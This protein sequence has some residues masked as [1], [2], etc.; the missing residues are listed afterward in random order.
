[1]EAQQCRK[2]ARPPSHRTQ[3]W[4][5]PF[6]GT[7]HSDQI[8]EGWTQILCWALWNMCF[9]GNICFRYIFY[10]ICICV[11]MSSLSCV[12]WRNNL[13]G[14][15][16]LTTFMTSKCTC[17]NLVRPHASTG[18]RP[19][20]PKIV[21]MRV[22]QFCKFSIQFAT[23]LLTFRDKITNRHGPG[24]RRAGPKYWDPSTGPKGPL[25]IL[26]L[27]RVIFSGMHYIKNC[28]ALTLSLRDLVRTLWR[29]CARWICPR[30]GI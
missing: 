22:P 4:N 18:M 8:C 26:N 14:R 7:P 3:G 30:G 15:S 2:S 12:Y 16:R 6:G 29:D 10:V 5:I 17:A 11:G 19:R 23:K 24:P 13:K 27:K 28:R 21:F 20:I 25:W 1:M 9:A